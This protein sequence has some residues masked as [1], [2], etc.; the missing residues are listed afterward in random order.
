MRLQILILS[1]L[2]ASMLNSDIDENDSENIK[3]IPESK[4]NIASDKISGLQS[5]KIKVKEKTGTILKEL[6]N[7]PSL[8]EDSKSDTRPIVAIGDLHGD[9]ENSIKVLLKANLIKKYD[10]NQDKQEKKVASDVEGWLGYTWN[11]I[12][13]LINTK[14]LKKYESEKIIHNYQDSYGYIWNGN[15][16]ILVQTGDIAD[17]GPHTLRIYQF[18]QLLKIQSQEK[19]GDVILLLGNHETMNL[20]GIF[21]L[22]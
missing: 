13:G 22:I 14:V 17:R 12:K 18:F 6:T 15:D 1:N 20:D 10:P 2:F 11:A 8:T 7:D 19:G 4:S 5:E 3:S 9:W 16:T 21:I